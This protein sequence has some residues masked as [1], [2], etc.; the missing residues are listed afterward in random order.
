MTDPEPR[1]VVPPATLARALA[2][3]RRAGLVV[4]VMPI[5]DVARRGPGAG[6][7]AR[8]RPRPLVDRLPRR[9]A[10]PRRRRPRRRGAPPGRGQRAGQPR[11]RRRLASAH[12]RDSPTLFG[13]PHLLRQLGSLRRGALLGRPGRGGRERLVPTPID[14]PLAAARR[15]AA[16]R[17]QPLVLTELGYPALASAAEQP[18]DQHTGAAPTNAFRRGCWRRA[19]QRRTP[20]APPAS[21][22]GTGSAGAARATSATA[23]EA[24][25]PPASWRGRSRAGP[26]GDRGDAAETG[27]LGCRWW[28]HCV[29]PVGAI[30][31]QEVSHARLSSAALFPSVLPACE[32]GGDPEVMPR[33]S[34]EAAFRDFMD[35]ARSDDD[36]SGY[37]NADAGGGGA[38][39]GG[40]AAGRGGAAPAAPAEVARP[41]A[42]ARPRTRRSP[43]TRRP[44][45]TRGASSRTSGTTWCSCARV[46][47]TR[48]M[49][50]RL[51]CLDRPIPSRWRPRRR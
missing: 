17:G 50:R 4:T 29:R 31:L 44:G 23:P 48:P 45:S 1:P 19:W 42:L 25:P 37:G 33:F 36:S 30:P 39:G 43:T 21:S 49:C 27:S 35:R 16:D 26:A 34:S 11:R 38:G 14:A 12:H 20:P 13:T 40:G 51:A 3:A 22:S 41:T 28:S 10:R 9:A 24:S 2:H 46:G 15:F 47:C 18:W 6:A 7:G 5:I 32:D 8:P